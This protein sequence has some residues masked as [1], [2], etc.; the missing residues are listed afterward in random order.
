VPARCILSG[1]AGY[2]ENVADSGIATCWAALIVAIRLHSMKE[3]LQ[4]M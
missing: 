4:R 1:P 3:K 2:G